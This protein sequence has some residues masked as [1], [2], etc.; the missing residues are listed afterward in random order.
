MDIVDKIKQCRSS[1]TNF[2][3]SRKYWHSHYQRDK[4][5][6]PCEITYTKRRNK[7]SNELQN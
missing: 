1:Y 2:D 7:V 5:E 4:L 6:L 3:M